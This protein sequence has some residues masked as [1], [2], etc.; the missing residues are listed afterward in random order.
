MTEDL[1]RS[2]ALPEFLDEKLPTQSF[3]NSKRDWSDYYHDREE[4]ERELARNG[5]F[6]PHF[7]G[8]LLRKAGQ[9]ERAAT[10]MIQAACVE[11]RRRWRGTL[12][13][14]AAIGEQI[15]VGTI[16]YYNNW[17]Y[18]TIIGASGER[19]MF[20]PPATGAQ[21]YRGLLLT[22]SPGAVSD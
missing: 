10:Q 12:D 1:D 16:G 17:R 2:R 6:T 4:I 22:R 7:L 19:L 14:V 11:K 5:T 13:L 18:L 20:D 8:S 9:T 3:P 15:S 21:Q